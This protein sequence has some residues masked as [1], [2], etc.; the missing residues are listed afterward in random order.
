MIKKIEQIQILV[1]RIKTDVEGLQ[2][3]E[4]DTLS[5]TEEFVT[6]HAN[7]IMKILNK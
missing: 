7:E 1:S 4:K 6:F 5:L 2:Y 3:H